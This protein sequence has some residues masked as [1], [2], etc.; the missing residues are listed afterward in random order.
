MIFIFL[1][2]AIRGQDSLN[3]CAI[4]EANAG[5]QYEGIVVSYD[6]NIQHFPK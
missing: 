1:V 5:F 3:G 2:V 4:E 6:R